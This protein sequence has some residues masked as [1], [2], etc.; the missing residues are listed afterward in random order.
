MIHLIGPDIVVL[1]GGL[2]EAIPEI[3]LEEVD[4]ITRKNVLECYADSFE[5]RVAKLGDDA[6][7]IGAAAHVA[8]QV[9][10]TV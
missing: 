3:Y 8:A 1:G 2:V 5:I 4:R 7:A 10:V 6:G 9:E